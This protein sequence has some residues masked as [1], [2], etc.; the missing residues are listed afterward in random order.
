M[1]PFGFVVGPTSLIVNCFFL[2][3]GCLARIERAKGVKDLLDGLVATLRLVEF[4]QFFVSRLRFRRGGVGSVVG[5]I[6]YCASL[7]AGGDEVDLMN[8]SSDR[9]F[10][11]R[12]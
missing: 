2:A 9:W 4:S 6:W 8:H 1:G 3:G 5:V 11:P 10:G 7:V 12:T